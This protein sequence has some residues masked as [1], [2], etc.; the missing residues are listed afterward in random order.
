MPSYKHTQ[1]GGENK[2]NPTG[3]G[4]D[5]AGIKPTGKKNEEL[6][7]KYTEGAD[8]NP[9]NTGNVLKNNDNRNTDKPELDNG[10]YN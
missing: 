2:G 1:P 10:K 3:Q 5:K 8:E 9:A 7:N 6:R 4:Q